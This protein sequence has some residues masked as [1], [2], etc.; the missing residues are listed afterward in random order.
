MVKRS[1]VKLIDHVRVKGMAKSRIRVLVFPISLV[2]NNFNGKRRLG[3][4][5]Y[6]IKQ[7]KRRECHK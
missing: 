5:F 6:K 4:L 3:Y 2:T 1:I 7:I